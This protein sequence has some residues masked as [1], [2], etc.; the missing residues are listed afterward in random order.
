MLIK[1]NIENEHQILN[2]PKDNKSQEK[3][4]GA[5]IRANDYASSIKNTDTSIRKGER[6]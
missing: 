4:F 3:I 1:A 2:K 6:A 5:H